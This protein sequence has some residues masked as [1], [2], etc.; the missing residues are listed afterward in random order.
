MSTKSLELPERAESARSRRRVFSASR[1]PSRQGRRPCQKLLP[2][3]L[4]PPESASA[5]IYGNAPNSFD[6]P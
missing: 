5:A 1:R 6:D 2:N 3:C 4:M